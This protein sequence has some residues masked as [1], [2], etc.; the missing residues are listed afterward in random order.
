[1]SG[2][3]PPP[4]VRAFVAGSTGT[5]KSYHL[6]NVLLA[7]HRKAIVLDF[8]GDFAHNRRELKGHVEIA[9]TL[10][11]L[12]PILRRMAERRDVWRVLA[13]LNQGEC[14]ALARAL[15]PERIYSG[16][17]VAKALGGCALVC[18]ELAQ[19]APHSA[20]P[21]IRALWQRGR[22]VGLTIL[23][24]SQAP[25]DVHPNVRGMSRYLVMFHLHEPNAVEYFARVVPPEGIA[26]ATNLGKHECLVWDTEK[27][28]G[29]HLAAN[30][31]VKQIIRPGE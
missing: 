12:K 30:A 1:M 16:A 8:T 4:S 27:R 26:I 13:M 5:G 18:D 9:E 6:R 7:N 17:S 24:A 22:H 3:V 15:V 25:T 19:F 21:A 2:Y 31:S 11:D 29:Y 10:D 28:I 23:G 20:D 14:I